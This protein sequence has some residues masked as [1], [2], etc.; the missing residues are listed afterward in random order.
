MRSNRMAAMTDKPQRLGQ[1]EQ[2]TDGPL[3]RQRSCPGLHVSCLKRT[4]R[5]ETKNR[6]TKMST[7]VLRHPFW[8]VWL[9]PASQ[10]PSLQF[11]VPEKGLSPGLLRTTNPRSRAT[12]SLQSVLSPHYT[13][14]FSSRWYVLHLLDPRSLVGSPARL[15]APAGSRLRREIVDRWGCRSDLSSQN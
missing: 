3:H 7:G 8:T 5:E 12:H 9:C 4:K 2:R 1:C 15:L 10:L 6:V 13:Y 11:L 14:S